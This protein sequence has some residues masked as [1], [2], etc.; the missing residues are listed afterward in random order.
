[1]AYNPVA[2]PSS[3]PTTSHHDLAASGLAAA[4]AKKSRRL[5]ADWK[6]EDGSTY[7]LQSCENTNKHE[8]GDNNH[9]VW[10]HNQKA[11]LK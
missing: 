1:M 3:F 9:E 5:P 7:Y 2:F 11:L 4:Q 10:H 6:E 8:T